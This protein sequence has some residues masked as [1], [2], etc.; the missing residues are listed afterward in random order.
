MS[1]ETAEYSFGGTS[2][3]VSVDMGNVDTDEKVIGG[4]AKGITFDSD[5]L[6][7]GTKSEPEDVADGS[8]EEGNS[9]DASGTDADE[10]GDGESTEV[11]EDAELGE[12]DPENEEVVAAYDARYSKDGKL[13]LEGVLS[14][15]YFSNAAKGVEGLNE[16][17]YKYLEAKGISRSAIKQVEAMA[18][19]QKAAEE[20][21]V[22]AHDQKLFDIAGGPDSLSQAL[23]WGKKGGYSAEQQERF[24]K[25]TK[26]KDFEA[27]Q[28][29]VEALMAR[30]RR[31]N[32]VNRPKLPKRDATKGQGKTVPGL[33]PFKDR[34]EM[35]QVRDSLKDNDTAGWAAF[36][37]RLAVTKE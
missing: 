31:A 14:Q 15:E 4:S 33:K 16:E 12:W 24:N 37:A 2:E 8:T 22:K 21:S 28:E 25:I 13:D 6:D 3:G 20:T 9:D 7:K 35:R 11:G 26:G 30:Y 29:A 32:P 10:E 27:K 1:K 18:Q 36:R 19:T 34:N 5:D 17:T 23:E